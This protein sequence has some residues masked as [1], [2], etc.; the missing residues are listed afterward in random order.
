MLRGKRDKKANSGKAGWRKIWK[1]PSAYHWA[2][3]YIR[4]GAALT[5]FYRLRTD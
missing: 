2:D 5:E 4:Q 1:L 3:Q